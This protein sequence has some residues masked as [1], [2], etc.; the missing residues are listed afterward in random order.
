MEKM[1]K[2]WVDFSL[3]IHNKTGKYFVARDV[4]D[5]NTDVIG[6]VLYWRMALASPPKG[7][8]GRLVG[9]LAHYETQWRTRFPAETKAA[10]G[11]DPGRPSILHMDPATTLWRRRIGADIVLCH[12]L[13]PVT[14]P[15]LFEPR[16]GALYAATYRHIARQQPQLVFV[17]QATRTEFAR[18][19][20]EPRRGTVI[21]NPLR[22]EVGRIEARRP[23][24]LE[25]DF[26]GPFFLTA[27]QLGRRKNQA[28]SIRA[29]LGSG[30]PERGYRYLVCGGQEPG[31]E[32]VV[33]AAAGSPAVR[34]LS[35]V[36][37]AELV[38][39]YQNATGFVL[40]SLLEGF[41]VPVIEAIK[42]GL[43]PL[44]TRASVLEEVGG[45]GALSA[46][47]TDEADI[48]RGLVAL[49]DMQEAERRQRVRQLREG[50]D[51]FEPEGIKAQWRGLLLAAARG[52][53]A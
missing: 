9:R 29:F 7:L 3:A 6:R 45:P 46:D 51:R 10:P 48:A 8:L 12:D 26:E 47:P 27:G 20:G 42:H 4:I 5:N 13:G 1:G 24:A 28:A 21:Y 17:S 38:W 43:V 32:E 2:I 25:A 35:Y 44:V 18:L 31:H 52:A 50:L 23:A 49:A 39:L 19:Y 16:V 15:E 53:P 33:A 14:H 40:M 30:L 34:I 37:D 41:G 11:G 36:G 22:D